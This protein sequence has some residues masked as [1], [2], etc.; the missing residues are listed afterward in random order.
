MKL[1]FASDSFKGTLSQ[2]KIISILTETAAEKLPGWECVGVPVADGGEGTVAAVVKAAG[3][4]LRSVA[5]HGPRMESVTAEYG[6]L[7][8]GKAII[9]MAAASG[10]PMVPEAERN[11]LD[12]TSFGFGELIAD[13][14][15]QGC[16]DISVA[17]GGSAT[18]D[19]GMGA[20]RALGWQ[21][22]DERGNNLHG[23]GRELGS[24]ARIIYVDTA[25]LYVNGH[26]DIPSEFNLRK[27]IMDT[28]FTIMCD[29]T[30]PLLGEH[31]ATYTFGPQKGADAATLA[32][33]EAGMEHYAAFCSAYLGKDIA[34]VPGAGAAGG[35]G[36]AL[37]G[38]LN[39]TMKSGI[40]TVL[41]LVNFQDTLRGATFCITGEGKLDNQS[42]HGKVVSGIV[43]ACKEQKVPCLA[44]VGIDQSAALGEDAD[45]GL[46][47]VY[48][49]AD[50]ASSP[51]DSMA[52][53]E[54]YYR[55]QASNLMESLP[56]RFPT[57]VQEGWFVIGHNA[58]K[59][60]LGKK[61][62]IVT[63]RHA[64][65][66]TGAIDDVIN[67]LR[68]Q[69]IPYV[70]FDEVEENPSR[71]T[72]MK[73][74]DFGLAE[75][76]DFVIGIGGGS[77]LDA[78]KAIALMMRH[79]GHGIE[80]LYE[81]GND[82]ALPVVAIPTTCGTGSEVTGVS[83]LTRYDKATKAS[84]PFKIYPTLALL[85]PQYLLF[86]SHTLIVHTAVDA[87][88]HMYESYLSSKSTDYN[89]MLVK[90]GLSYWIKAK[91]FLTGAAQPDLDDYQNLLMASMYAGLAIAQTG[92]SIPHAISYEITFHAGIPHGQACG[93]FL[94]GY[95]AQAAK[96]PAI[97][98]DVEDLLKASEFT[99][100][101]LRDFIHTTC[102]PISVSKELMEMDLA[103]LAENKAKLQTAPFALTL[104]DLKG[105]CVC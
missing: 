62:L 80:Y 79:P 60:A 56:L 16:R 36:A 27:A 54:Y 17:L 100:D 40:E 78:A 38:F 61:A 70:I 1:V 74:R 28:R 77:P 46:E 25:N 3:G 32:Q 105:M 33:L 15:L 42:L 68:S 86:A 23:F 71:E 93:W 24:V 31:G 53:A 85:D 57:E 91:D 82:T 69:K 72:V 37:Y 65:V 99:L 94:P 88:A 55:Q 14:L 45:T 2:E 34:S 84:I 10:L 44:L 92:T 97:S 52:H 11:P 87:L 90:Q 20:L 50:L 22:Q 81:G 4:Q 30:N 19:G 35:L 73:G 21:F 66:A 96:C 29:V 43:Q 18:N 6:L 67:A 76:A 103:H 48:A 49:T 83:V 63:G 95:L 41:D 12:T 75:G 8:S 89:K 26:T 101:T 13:A 51:E 5:V 47:A 102:G 7:P 58:K 9:E 64:A 98:K 39:G 59:M 104:D